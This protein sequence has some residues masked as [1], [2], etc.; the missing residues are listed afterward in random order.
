MVRLCLRS[1]NLGASVIKLCSLSFS[2]VSQSVATLARQLQSRKT[3]AGTFW[4]GSLFGS[5]PQAPQGEKRRWKQRAAQHRLR[6]P[7]LSQ[8]NREISRPSRRLYYMMLHL[9][10][11]FSFFFFQMEIFFY[12]ENRQQRDA[13]PTQTQS[14]WPLINFMI[15][16]LFFVFYT[17]HVGPRT[18]SWRPLHTRYA[19]NQQHAKM[20]IV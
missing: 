3:T 13:D 18:T 5:K 7:Q 1:E 14:R 2:L 19:T 4:A 11:I 12:S 6:F 10:G 16:S 15:K 20:Q 17:E 8:K 9:S